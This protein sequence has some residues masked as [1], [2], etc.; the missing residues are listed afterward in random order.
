[1]IQLHLRHLEYLVYPE[2]LEYLD[3]LNLGILGNLEFPVHLEYLED[4]E[5]QM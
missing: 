3:Q 1:M 5:E 2:V 4:H